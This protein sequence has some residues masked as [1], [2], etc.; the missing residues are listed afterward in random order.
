ML[1]N[2]GLVGKQRHL[3]EAGN[4][5]VNYHLLK[6]R[7]PTIPDLGINFF[8]EEHI[9]TVKYNKIKFKD[10]LKYLAALHIYG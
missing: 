5:W 4:L 9:L 2:N 7:M 6:S 1:R 3:E 8:I 10:K